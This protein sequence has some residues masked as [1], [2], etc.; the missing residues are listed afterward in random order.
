MEYTDDNMQLVAEK[1]V[2]MTVNLAHTLGLRVV[3]EGIEDRE[4]MLQLQKLGCDVAQGYHIGRPMPETAFLNWLE[5]QSG[6][7]IRSI[8]RAMK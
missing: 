7:N 1:I 4:T 3:A 8:S 5:K 2:E 6:N